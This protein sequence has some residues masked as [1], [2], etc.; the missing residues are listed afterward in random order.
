MQDSTVSTETISLSAVREID[1]D[2]LLTWKNDFALVSM[3]AGSPVPLSREQIE[4]WYRGIQSDK[5]QVCLG[6]YCTTANGTQLIGIT[7]LMF[8]DWVS[9]TAEFGM[10]I[11]PNSLR[12]KGF[13][14]QALQSTISH[15]FT[16]LNLNR[17]WLRVT[18]NNSAAIRIYEKAGFK[19]EGLLR[20]HYFADGRQHNMIVM[21]LLRSEWPGT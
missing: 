20:E 17:I 11:G 19:R 16:K 15:A 13:G 6:V 7:R 2:L 21:G 3:I 1:L 9:R 4:N 5:N 18:E 12:G 10:L 8:I 14:Y